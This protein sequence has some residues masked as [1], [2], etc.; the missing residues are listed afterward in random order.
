M[1]RFDGAPGSCGICIAIRTFHGHRCRLRSIRRPPHFQS[2]RFRL[3]LRHHLGRPRMSENEFAIASGLLKGNFPDIGHHHSRIVITKTLS[4][5]RYLGSCYGLAS[6]SRL[7][8]K[9]CKPRKEL[10]NF[11]CIHQCLGQPAV[12]VEF[13]H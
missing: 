2:A 12:F 6:A 9:I 3:I 8:E 10:V 4:S 13:S 11:T 7:R 5:R 1:P